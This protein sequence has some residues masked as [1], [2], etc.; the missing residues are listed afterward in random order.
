[1][2]RVEHGSYGER[3]RNGHE[4]NLKERPSLAPGHHHLNA[5]GA[6]CGCKALI[7]WTYLTTLLPPCLSRED[8][9]ATHT[10]EQALMAR[11]HFTKGSFSASHR[12]YRAHRAD[13]EVS[14]GGSY[15]SIES[16]P[17][18]AQFLFLR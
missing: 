14:V 10:R 4:S 18:I 6:F 1:M 3:S 11:I 9:S 5:L 7:A 16:I 13:L 15:A 12:S 2:R 17:L 8:F